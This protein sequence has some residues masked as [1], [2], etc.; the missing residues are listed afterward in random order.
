MCQWQPQHSYFL[1]DLTAYRISS[2]FAAIRC[3]GTPF[4]WANWCVS[5]L[6]Q[7]Y[8]M[9]FLMSLSEPSYNPLGDRIA[10]LAIEI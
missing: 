8:T 7:I 5:L 6:Q 2:I 4:F 9:L 1:P 10:V 3:R